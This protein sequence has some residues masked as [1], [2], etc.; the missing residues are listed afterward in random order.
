MLSEQEKADQV[1]AGKGYY[2]FQSWNKDYQ[3]AFTKIYGLNA[4]YD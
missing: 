1:K 2:S 3:D 4:Y